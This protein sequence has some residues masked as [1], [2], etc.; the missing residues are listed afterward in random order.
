MKKKGKIS[1]QN[2]T[3]KP[4]VRVDT[5]LPNGICRIFNSTVE[6]PIWPEVSAPKFQ[7]V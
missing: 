2:K 6:Q 4:N 1:I 3:T 7:P 5:S